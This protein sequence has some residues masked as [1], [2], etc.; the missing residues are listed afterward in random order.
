VKRTAIWSLWLASL[1]VAFLAGRGAVDNRASGE[2]PAAPAAPPQRIVAVHPATEPVQGA[3][4]A[5]NRLGEARELIRDGRP[6]PALA[7]VEDH[8]DEFADDA[9]ALFLL[10]DLRQMT[11]DVDAALDP[12]IDILRFPPT[13]EEADRARRRLDLL[14][15][16]REQQL[17]HAGDLAGLVAYFERLV[18]AEPTWDGHRLRLARWLARSGDR[19]AAARLLR[20][21]GTA[22]VTQDEIDALTAEIELA[23]ASLP[24]ERE[25]GM[26]YTRAAVSGSRRSGSYRLL[27][28]TG[29]TMTG[30]ARERLIALG[31]E[32]VTDRVS[33]HTAAG[34]VTLP[35]YR[36]AELKL[37]PIVL[38]DLEVLGFDELPAG[39]DGL[40]GTDVLGQLSG[41]LSGAVG[42]L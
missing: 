3:A 29:A 39:A 32:Q 38:R 24:V 18:L 19:E 11:G 42:R 25:A 1:V 17:I 28:D 36:I 7:L 23:E 31:A 2:R 10:S 26:L 27:V 20:E 33:V 15:N 13:T 34:V 30:F 16:A 41:G 14:I 37:G 9:E 22:G 4:R 6:L 40:L 8:L 21:V 12:L 5:V 35:V